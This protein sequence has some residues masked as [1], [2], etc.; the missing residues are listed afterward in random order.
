MQAGAKHV[1]AI[2]AS[3]MATYA[4]K[5]T[6]GNPELGR[7]ITVRRSN[8]LRATNYNLKTH[9]HRI[10]MAFKLNIMLLRLTGPLTSKPGFCR[11]WGVSLVFIVMI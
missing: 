10:T 11:E 2:E 5:L 7:N 8:L 3:K 9:Y 1:Y 4:S 6:A